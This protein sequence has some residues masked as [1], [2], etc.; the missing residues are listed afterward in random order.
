MSFAT[1]TAAALLAAAALT[2]IGAGVASAATVPVDTTT[3]VHAAQFSRGFHV[4][5]NTKETLK[6]DQY[7]TSGDW[8]GRPAV[9][10]DIN[11]GGDFDFETTYDAATTNTTGVLIDAYDAQGHV[12]PDGVTL[13]FSVDE[14]GTP[15]VSSNVV[16]GT[17]LTI[18]ISGSNVYVNDAS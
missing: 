5:N 10:S 1:K 17:G 16:W 7:D 3:G 12:T 18:T 2:G 13:H 6:V 14:W 15:S 8:T 4:Y 9:G 11:N